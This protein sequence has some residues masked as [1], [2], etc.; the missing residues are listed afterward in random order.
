MHNIYDFLKGLDKSSNVIECGGSTGADTRQL[1]NY[2][3]TGSVYTIEANK[4]LY[5]NLQKIMLNH[6]NL[7]VFN[8][9]LADHNGT[10]S[11][12]I[13]ENP[14]GDAGASSV[15]ESNDFYLRDY[16]KKEEK[17]IV[18]CQTLENFMIKNKIEKLNFLWLDIEGYEYFVLEGSKNILKNIQYIYTEVN[19]QNFRKNS[20]LYE[21]IKKLLIDCGFNEIYKW[22]QGAKW[23]EWQG[24][25]LFENKFFQ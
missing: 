17:T 19:F 25:V 23:G 6:S 7:Q 2:F 1:C 9:A 8:V 10:T 22:E 12:Y 24:N 15:L 4:N 5:E 21:D 11:F 20:K 14:E 3:S 18:E 16:I 13:D